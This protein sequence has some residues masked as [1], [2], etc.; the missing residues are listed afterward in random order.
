MSSLKVGFI[1][2]GNMGMAMAKP[3]VKKGFQVTVCD[4]NPRAVEEIT[5]LGAKAANSPREL[6][7]NSDVIITMVRDIEQTDEVLF[8]SEGAWEGLKK[9]A[10]IMISN[11]IGPEY[12]RSLYEKAKEKGFKVVDCAV[13]DPSG[14]LHTVEG[15]L[16][17]MIGGDEEDVQICWSIFEA[18]GKNIFHLGGIGMG[19]TYK[20]VNNLATF[21]I[22]MVNREVLNFG[23]KAGLDLEKMTEVICASTGG[24]WI[25]WFQGQLRK[26]S[27]Q[28]VS[29]TQ[30]PPRNKV[31]KN[32]A[33]PL[34]KRLAAEMA[35][36]VGARLPID[37]FMNN[38]DIEAVYAD[39]LAKTRE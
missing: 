22:G 12:C 13:S 1:G 8:G 9:N 17:L 33:V 5:A 37:E 3:L 7:E 35:R 20:L 38:L 21:N 19:Q 14:S 39:Y 11:S 34:E 29:T 4:L 27:K 32:A 10:I 31:G 24:S 26:A 23:L 2:V 28:R 16:T 25:M 30:A 36:K 15:G 6:A 18:I